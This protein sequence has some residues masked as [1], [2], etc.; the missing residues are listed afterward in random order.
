[1]NL[2]DQ[3]NKITR[4]PYDIENEIANEV[5]RSVD[6]AIKEAVE[7]TY[8]SIM[9][10][11]LQ[12]AQNAQYE[13]VENKRKIS[14]FSELYSLS[15]TLKLDNYLGFLSS[16]GSD[17]IQDKFFKFYPDISM[18]YNREDKNYTLSCRLC[19]ATTHELFGRRYNTFSLTNIAITIFNGV[20]NKAKED[21]IEV[22]F[23]HIQD[24]WGHFTAIP[25]DG[26]NAPFIGNSDNG[27]IMLHYSITF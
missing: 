3:L 16:M 18:Y 22:F 26:Y 7:D 1:M 14:G 2:K 4:V 27:K 17:D 8:R 5:N 9:N 23:S 11:I 24:T 12:K 20:V 21:D 10:D 6:E 19:R 15:Y 13:M 25:R